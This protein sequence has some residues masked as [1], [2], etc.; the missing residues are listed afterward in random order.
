[1]TEP[2]FL[3]LIRRLKT[4]KHPSVLGFVDALET[5]KFLW[6]VTSPVRPLLA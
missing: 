5:E 1:M 6:L 2:V 4:M 3:A